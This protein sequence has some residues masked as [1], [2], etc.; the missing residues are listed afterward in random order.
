M[1]CYLAEST[2]EANETFER[3]MEK[4]F[5]FLDSITVHAEAHQHTLYDRI[6][7]LAR[8]S[9][10]PEDAV[11]RLRELIDY[12]EVTDFLNVTQFAGHLSHEQ[13]TRSIRLFA[14]RVMPHFPPGAR[15]G[16]S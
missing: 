16:G 13:I 6:P 15:N 9:G 3:G 12:F 14:D 5:G 11:E 4:Y 7:T 1:F 2:A 10:S 8:L